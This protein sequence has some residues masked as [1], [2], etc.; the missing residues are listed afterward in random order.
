ME[1]PRI[2]ITRSLSLK[3]AVDEIPFTYQSYHARVREAGGEPVDLH[4]ALAV[5]PERLIEALDGLVICGGPDIN[6]ARYGQLPRPETAGI[7]DGRDAL[8]LA[9]I[10]LAMARDLPLLAICRGHQALNV[11]CGGPLLQHIEGDGHRA[12]AG[13]SGDSR[14][15]DITIAAG[16]RLYRLLG[17]RRMRANSRHH[18]A[19]TA[20]GVAPGLVPTAWSPDGLVEGL[21]S[22]AHRWL[23]GVQW[24]PERDEVKDAFRV[25][26]DD[27]VRAAAARAAATGG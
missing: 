10:Q 26:F 16:S 13:G 27:F 25:L 14:F 8:E 7:D 20:D 23:L 15:H 22:P 24:H 6:P 19:V 17:A 5:P 11:A 12:H 3:R 9:L 18:Q 2:G 1:R 21:E 4:P